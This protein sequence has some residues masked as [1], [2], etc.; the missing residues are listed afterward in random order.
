MA[1]RSQAATDFP[2]QV[3]EIKTL[4]DTFLDRIEH[5]DIRQQVRSLIP[6]FHALRDLG[7]GL[8]K[9]EGIKAG[10]DRIL[11]YLRKYPRTVID[12][13]ELMVVAGIGEWARRT[14]ELRVEFGWAIYTGAT[15]RDQIEETPE[16]IEE[17]QKVIGQDPRK[18]LPTDYVL[19]KD[20]QD[21]EAALRWNQLKKI[22]NKSGGVKAKVLEYLRL[23]VGHVVTG[24]ELRYLAKD[25]KEWA[26]RARELRTEDGW[27]V[28]TRMQGRPDLGVG[29]YLLEEDRQA[30]EHDRQISDDVRVKV[31]ERDNFS[32]VFCGWKHEDLNRNDPRKFLELHHVYDHAKGGQNTVENLVTLC[33]VHHDQVHRA[34]LEWSGEKW[35]EK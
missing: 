5:D 9:G 21:R 24:E 30:P 11:A 23:N 20:E 3:N 22:R 26:R 4:L 17:L 10:R 2:K 34:K 6:A 35:L 12:G 15:F 25:R 7:S 33:N 27:P 31:L 32:C 19:M 13:D 29:E 16:V 28:L 18:L 1:R 8:I 14:R